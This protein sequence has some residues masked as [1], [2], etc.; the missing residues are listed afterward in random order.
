MRGHASRVPLT[1][2]LIAVDSS[3]P[4][5]LHSDPV[6]LWRGNAADAEQL[7]LVD[8]RGARLA[9]FTWPAG[10][11]RL[12]VPGHYFENGKRYLLQRP[13]QPVNLRVHKVLSLP[14]N[15]A[16]LAAWMARNGCK[17]QALIVLE[18]L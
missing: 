14:N 2:D 12:A 4:R 1:A 16:A 8:A 9:S 6:V 13:N 10:E 18:G 17:A 5:C 7:T 11:A 15:P 3:G